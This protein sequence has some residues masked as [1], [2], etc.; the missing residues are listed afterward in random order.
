MQT[1]VESYILW[2]RALVDRP[3]PLYHVL[4][5]VAWEVPYEYYI[6]NDDNR[7]EDG[8]KLREQFE[9]ETSLELPNLGECRMLEF[10]IALAIRLNETV[11][12]YH[13]PNQTSDWFWQLISNLHLDGF[14]DEHHFNDVEHH[15]MHR[16]R[17][18]NS[19]QYGYNGKGGLFPL[20]NPI[21]DQRQVEV[22]YQMMAYLF[23]NM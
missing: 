22:W 11:Y 21:A 7:A 15:I 9:Q 13:N 12:D 16:F 19:R 14:D 1:V 18:V 5:D 6:P 20:E 8:L 23:E 3:G 4:F 10:L 2:L 17:I